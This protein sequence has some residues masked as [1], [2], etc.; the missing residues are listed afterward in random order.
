MKK[1][2][3]ITLLSFNISVF[4]NVLSF[5]LHCEFEN[6]DET[7]SIKIPKGAIVPKGT[8]SELG[9][10]YYNLAELQIAAA[11][12]QTLVAVRPFKLLG[13]NFVHQIVLSFSSLY[14]QSQYGQLKDGKFDLSGEDIGRCKLK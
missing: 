14:I 11:D 12:K 13:E 3:V 2:L 8:I 9:N 4:P 6:R 1:L 10:L 7:A 5:D